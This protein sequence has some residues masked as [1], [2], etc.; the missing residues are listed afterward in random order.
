MESPRFFLAVWAASLVALGLSVT[1]FNLLIDPYDVF[2]TPRIAGISVIKPAAKNHALLAKTYQ[3]ARAHPVTVLIGS[4]STHIGIDAASDEW[5]PAMR[6]VYNY[7]IPGGY[8]TSTSLRTLQEAVSAGGVRN[9]IVFLDFQ[10]FLVPE[11]PGGEPG[12][13]ERRYRV[14]YDGSPNPYRAEQM[15][16]DR[17][18]ALGTMGAFLDSLHTVAVQYVRDALNLAPDGSS[19]EAD[20]INAA[21]SDGMHDLFEQKNDLESQRAAGL[22]RSM[23]GWKGPLPNLGIVS[24]MIAY[25]RSR[26]VTLTLVLT[27]HHADTMEVYWRNGLWPRIEQLKSELAALAAATDPKVAFWDFMDYSPYATERIPPAGDRRTPTTWFWEPTHFKKRLGAIMIGRMFDKA[28]QDFGEALTPDNV[29]ARNAAVRSQRQAIFCEG[30]ADG[31]L[32]RTTQ[33]MSDGCGPR[34]HVAP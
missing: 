24:A 18:L 26:D 6:P 33:H 19:T 11:S 25:A 16:S 9:A 14:T 12:E 13:D 31:L 32:T 5:P 15:A 3:E 4:S 30:K 34:G 2:G 21:R 7:G 22:K 28:P 20:F 23:A 8:A 29:D 17:F 27:P 1:G 10:N